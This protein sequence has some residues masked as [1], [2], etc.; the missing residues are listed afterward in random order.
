MKESNL[1][2]Y[3]TVAIINQALTGYSASPEGGEGNGI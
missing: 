3:K 1:L 2:K